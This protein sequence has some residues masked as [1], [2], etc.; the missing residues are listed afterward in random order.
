[1]N[2]KV[3]LGYA[4][5]NMGLTNRKKKHG[6]KVTTSRT[7]RKATWQLGS[8]NPEDWD[9]SLVGERA[10]LN[11]TDLLHYLKWNEYICP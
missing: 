5:V 11:A 2:D 6:G 10:L 8:D 4:C 9:Y 3:R 1:M 7:A